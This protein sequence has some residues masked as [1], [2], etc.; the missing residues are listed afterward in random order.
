MKRLRQIRSL[1]L[2]PAVFWLLIQLSMTG[3]AAA[4]ET[5]IG[6]TDDLG[7]KALGLEQVAICSPDGAVA[8]NVGANGSSGQPH[9][10]HCEWCQ[11][12]GSITAPPVPDTAATATQYSLPV[13]Y[14]LAAARAVQRDGIQTGFSSRAPP[15]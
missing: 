1:A 2:V 11:A 13:K 12:F 14:R 6:G 10:S 3:V 8:L 15:A 4:P 5:S 7:W 9:A